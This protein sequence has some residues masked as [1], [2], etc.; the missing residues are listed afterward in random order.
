MLMLDIVMSGEAVYI[1]M[2]FEVD[3]KPGLVDVFKIVQLL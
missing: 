3:H 2:L 1:D